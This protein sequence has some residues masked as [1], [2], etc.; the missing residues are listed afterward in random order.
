MIRELIDARRQP[1]RL[2]VVTSDKA[3]YSYAKTLGARSCA[4]TSGTQL[5]RRVAPGAR[6]DPDRGRIRREAGSGDRLSGW[7]KKFGGEED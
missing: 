7:L 2:V 6:A 3:L 1:A 5:E 4:P